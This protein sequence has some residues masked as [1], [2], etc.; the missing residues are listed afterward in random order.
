MEVVRRSSSV[1]FTPRR[2]LRISRSVKL[3]KL[4]S[5][6]ALLFA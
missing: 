2:D 1:L 4:K 5:P 6:V 3:L